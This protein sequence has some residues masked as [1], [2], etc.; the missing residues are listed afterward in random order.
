MSTMD[1][2]NLKKSLNE[3]T[4][5]YERL[6]F[7]YLT[8]PEASLDLGSLL[9]KYP[10][11]TFENVQTVKFTPFF[12]KLVEWYLKKQLFPYD[13][14][15]ERAR[16]KALVDNKEVP[17]SQLGDMALLKLDREEK[18]MLYEVYLES[19]ELLNHFRLEKVKILQEEAKKLGFNNYLALWGVQT[20][21]DVE[22]LRE[23]CERFLSGTRDLYKTTL[24]SLLRNQI[25]ISLKEAE[26][27]DIR[28]LFLGKQSEQHF[29]GRNLLD[30]V[31]KT[32]DGLDIDLHQITGLEI[33]ESVRKNLT[34]VC[35]AID[36][37]Q[38]IKLVYKPEGSYRSFSSIVR[39]AAHAVHLAL[40]DSDRTAYSCDH[41]TTEG[42]AFLFGNLFTKP[43]FLIKMFG[44]R[45]SK[46]REDFTKLFNASMLTYTR[47]YAASFLYQKELYEKGTDDSR[48]AYSR[49]LND[50]LL[51][52]NYEEF[53]LLE[54]DPYKSGVYLIG[55]ILSS[56]LEKYLS[57]RHGR[58]WH[59]KPAAGS[60]IRLLM[61]FGN[62]KPDELVGMCGYSFTEQALIDHFESSL[63]QPTKC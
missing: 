41:S 32:F 34:S 10:F 26:R 1:L 47:T 27:Y 40:I 8:D 11:L 23:Q 17:V 25:G 19:I 52:N 43:S 3:L 48:I 7:V 50:A 42:W 4:G 2:T 31:Y 20:G 14:K 57:G 29:V 53:F 12:G 39:E 55:A 45:D 18:Q 28:K 56:I 59:E 44:M 62:I 38:V 54:A 6:L 61:S 35:L 9:E 13:Y 16:L 58:R 24:E 36:P 33:V 30:V 51:S 21:I 46:E 60:D 15:I 63:K 49:I 37:P 5:E 22:T